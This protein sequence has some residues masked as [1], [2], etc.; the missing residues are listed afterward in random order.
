[1]G[2]AAELN[3][4]PVCRPCRLGEPSPHITCLGTIG[5]ADRPL[6]PAIEI[7]VVASATQIKESLVSLHDPSTVTDANWWTKPSGGREVLRLAAPL[8]V[9]SLSLKITTFVDRMILACDSGPPMA[10][11][12]PA[13]RAWF[14]A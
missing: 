7:D 5:L 9:S 1:M 11:A 8:V 12:F 3:I 14:A 6:V 4:P 10:A 13:S 2:A